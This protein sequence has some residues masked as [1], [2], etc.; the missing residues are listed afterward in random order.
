MIAPVPTYALY[1]LAAIP[2]DVIVE[3]D[4]ARVVE[5]KSGRTLL[6]VKVSAASYKQS[7]V[8]S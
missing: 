6:D 4:T 5:R 1:G 7:R 2:A 8:Q 3:G